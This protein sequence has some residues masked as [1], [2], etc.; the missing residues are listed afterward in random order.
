MKRFTFW[1]L[2]VFVLLGFLVFITSVIFVP[3]GKSALREQM[4]AWKEAV[5]AASLEEYV[6]QKNQGLSEIEVQAGDAWQK[7]LAAVPDF[8]SAEGLQAK[9]TFEQANDVDMNE[10]RQ[11]LAMVSDSLALA[12]SASEADVDRWPVVLGESEETTGGFSGTMGF[13]AARSMARI[14]QGE[15][16]A[17]ARQGDLHGALES[18]TVGFRLAEYIRN[19]PALISHLVGVAIQYLM[20]E[21]LWSII[22]TADTPAELPD[23]EPLGDVLEVCMMRAHVRDALTGEVEFNLEMIQQIDQARDTQQKKLG[24]SDTTYP[25]GLGQLL[26]GHDEAAYLRYMSEYINYCDQPALLRTDAAAPK[27][28]PFWAV[29]SRLLA[30]ALDSYVRTITQSDARTLLVRQAIQL[31]EFFRENNAFPSADEFVSLATDERHGFVITYTL[32]EGGHTVE[33][34]C[35]PHADLNTEE[36]DAVRQETWELTW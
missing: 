22:Q 4:A 27:S 8:T 19:Q 36:A 9:T 1:L 21:T 6:A 34:G 17:R 7:A 30:P 11:S 15:A 32:S 12:H 33:L 29:M 18:V 10:L 28:L 14:L 26:L 5:G 24:G 23:L 35:E 20:R 16:F 25:A 31:T 3:T 13:A 2:G